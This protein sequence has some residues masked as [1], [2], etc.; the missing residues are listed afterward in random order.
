MKV[1]THNGRCHAD[2]VFA[3]AT[4][5]LK[6]GEGI[7]IV[8]TRDD[9]AIAAADIVFDVGHVYSPADR[10]FDHHQPDAP[11]PRENGVPYAAFGLVW[12]EFGEDIC[13]DAEVAQAVDEKLA[14]PIDASD[15]G[16]SID[17]ARP[18]MPEEFI[19]DDVFKS[20]CP[21][22]LEDEARHDAAFFE[23]VPFARRIL[24][25]V[26]AHA[27]ASAKGNALAAEA[28]AKGEDPRLLVLD[29]PYPWG[30]VEAANP[31]L[32]LAVSPDVFADRWNLRVVQLGGFKNKMDLP[33]AWAGLR[34]EALEV[35][36]GVPGASFCH[37]GRHFCAA[38]TRE[39]ALALAALA[40]AD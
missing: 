29:G 17:D 36:T 3:A 40:L 11:A 34:G 38:K 6:F 33:A 9:A 23:A 25:R 22:W 14:Q 19:M 10:R 2:D 7:E 8:R 13:G 20:F 26:I 39:A 12:Q 32:L 18:G 31:E 30:K 4:L 27:A 24:E 1:V 28:Y 16:F 5:Q 15:N 37:R 35:A 21:T